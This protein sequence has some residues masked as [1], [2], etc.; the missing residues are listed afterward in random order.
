MADPQQRRRVDSQEASARKRRDVVHTGTGHSG[1]TLTCYLLN[2]LS[3]TVALSEP[4]SPGKFADALPDLDAVA[5]GVEGFYRRMRRM[6]LKNGV[7]KSK[8]VG[9]V[10]PD[11][12]K[13]N[14]DGERRRVV[15]KGRIPV[16]KDLSPD[17]Q[18]VVKQPGLFTALLP[19]LV[20]RFPCYA[21]VR[22]PLPVL[23]SVD[24]V[25]GRPTGVPAT[26]RYDPELARRLEAAKDP[27]DAHL[28]RLDF[29]FARY[30]ELLPPEHLFRDEDLVA[31]GGRALAVINAR[32]E[33][34][35]EPL[36]SRNLNPLYAPE[37]MRELGQRL[38]ASEG[39]YWR[40]YT[41]E[42]VEE[43]LQG[44]D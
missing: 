5:R 38:L 37:R 35:D 27:V 18:L 23:A 20:E 24:S 42:G 9:G 13:G 31:S 43:L 8:H 44:M 3:D 26:A 28:R 7:V 12:Q 21:I 19:V 22:N 40:V 17:F 32:A 30:L 29:H 1:T 10:V 6:A 16:G 14:V 33:E 2:K 36:E 39:A 15:E 11:N 41:R 34:L 4:I 25:T